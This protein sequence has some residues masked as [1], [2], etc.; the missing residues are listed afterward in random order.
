MQNLLKRSLKLFSPLQI[1]VLVP[2]WTLHLLPKNPSLIGLKLDLIR[3]P[4]HLLKQVLN[5]QL[6][7]ISKPLKPL[8]IPD[9][10]MHG[11]RVTLQ[12]CN[13]LIDQ[14]NLPFYTQGFEEFWVP[15]KFFGQFSFKILREVFVEVVTGHETD[16]SLGFW[17]SV[18]LFSGAFG[19]FVGDGWLLFLQFLGFVSLRS[20]EILQKRKRILFVDHVAVSWWK[21]R[22]SMIF[23]AYLR[24]QTGVK[25]LK[26]MFLLAWSEFLHG[27]ELNSCC[28]LLIV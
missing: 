28:N 17:L 18:L 6:L 16:E 10:V 19:G 8:P 11:H 26:N 23:T 22:R 24:V 2:L 15:V 27:L 3:P 20:W 4:H 1:K 12:I 14:L 21:R 13:D 25:V 5:I 9:A 7:L